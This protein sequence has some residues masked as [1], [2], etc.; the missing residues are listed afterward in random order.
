MQHNVHYETYAK[1]RHFKGRDKKIQRAQATA[2]PHHCI[3][4][5]VPVPCRVHSVSET[6][7]VDHRLY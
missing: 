2:V 6:A 7:V 1:G 5:C 3:P 4:P